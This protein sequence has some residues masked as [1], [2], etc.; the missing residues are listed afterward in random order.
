[1]QN[2]SRLFLFG[3]S[4]LVLLTA[5]CAGQQGT[6]TATPQPSFTATVPSTDTPAATET[7]SMTVTPDTTLTPGIP[8]T[9]SI[10][11]LQCQFCLDNAAH[12]LLVIPAA[13]TVTILTPTATVSSAND[14]DTSCSSVETFRDKQVVLCR[15]PSNT[16]LNLNV[17]LDNSCQQFTVTLQTCPPPT[18]NTASATTTVT[19]SPT[20]SRTPA[21]SPTTSPTAVSSPT[22]A[23]TSTPPASP[24]AAT[25]TPTA[26]AT[27]TPTP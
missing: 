18:L 1:M 12:A 19:V 23:A 6:P 25:A 16:S 5:A 26:S 21:A 22:G 7:A 3:A 13:A 20:V 9:G 15:A 8:I 27:F 17:C 14:V 11:S 2:L 4:I 24:A 10:V